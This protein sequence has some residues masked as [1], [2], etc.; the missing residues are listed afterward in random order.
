MA[1]VLNSTEIARDLIIAQIKAC[2]PAAMAEMRT[3]RGDAKIQSEPPKKYFISE[4]SKVHQLPAV[5]VITGSVVTNKGRGANFANETIDAV[6]TVLVSDKS[7]EKLTI[8]AERYSLVIKKL[9]D[10]VPLV[11]GDGKIKIVPIVSR[12]DYSP[13]FKMAQNDTTFLKEGALETRIE[14]F[15]QQY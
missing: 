15:E 8:K 14:Y 2:F 6:I 12:L 3:A 5:Y 7:S 13:A 10:G 1:E 4:A 9:L 11:S